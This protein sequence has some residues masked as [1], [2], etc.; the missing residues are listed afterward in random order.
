VFLRICS[1]DAE[2]PLNEGDGLFVDVADQHIRK[3]LAQRVAAKLCGV[4]PRTRHRMLGTEPGCE[5]LATSECDDAADSIILVL[6]LLSARV[7]KAAGLR[8]MVATSAMYV[9]DVR[10]AAA[11]AF[12]FLRETVD[13]ELSADR[14]VSQHLASSLACRSWLGKLVTKPAPLARKTREDTKGGARVTVPEV[15]GSFVEPFLVL[16]WN[17]N[18]VSR[19]KSAQAP[20]DDRSWPSA[21][22]LDA[23]QAEVLRWHP[24]V[25]AL[26]EVRGAVA[27]DRFAADYTLIGSHAGHA[28]KAGFFQLYVKKAFE[29]TLVPMM[30]VPGVASVVRVR[31]ID[32]VFVAM[33]LEN[34]SRGEARR[35]KHLRLAR[36]IASATSRNLVLLAT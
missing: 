29:A 34:G 26:Q 4:L 17:V 27:L 10:H 15:D 16:S 6:G 23:V 8:P 20:A 24:G 22:N 11:E 3:T 21:D 9:Q 18:G 2:S 28:E 32:V 5:V 19:P 13:A 1:S 35:L 12:A 7:G 14:D 33:H 31:D 30:G 36:G 25:F